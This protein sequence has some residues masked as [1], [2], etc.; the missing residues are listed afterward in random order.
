MG[1]PPKNIAELA[2][3]SD[4][5]STLTGLLADASLDTTL[6]GDGPFTVF[7]PT[8]KAFEVLGD[9]DLTNEELKNVLLYHVTSA[10]FCH[11]SWRTDRRSKRSSPRPK[12]PCPRLCG[13]PPRGIGAGT[14][15]SGWTSF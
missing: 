2:A 8:N 6:S 4:D 9:V 11:R 13:F 15:G 7:A 12:G 10:T 1:I 5:L 14:V 3:E